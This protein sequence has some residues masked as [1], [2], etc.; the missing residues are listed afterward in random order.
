MI[1]PE[2][3]DQVNLIMTRHQVSAASGWDQINKLLKDAGVSYDAAI[4]PEQLG[5][6]LANRSGLL[7]DVGRAHNIGADI[8]SQGWVLSKTQHATC[9]QMPKGQA[10]RDA[11]TKAKLFSLC[12]CAPTLLFIA[13]SRLRNH[14][15]IFP[16]KRFTLELAIAGIFTSICTSTKSV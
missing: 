7:A 2:L 15:S 16:P 10:E 4:P 3:K 9:F 6:S 1:S 11:I 12:G 14:K 5:V 8:T 13:C